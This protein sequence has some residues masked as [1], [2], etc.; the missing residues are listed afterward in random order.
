MKLKMVSAALMVAF[1]TAAGAAHAT[2]KAKDA[3]DPV[4][5]ASK[6][7]K[8]AVESATVGVSNR[9]DAAETARDVTGVDGKAD[10]AK[11][12]RPKKD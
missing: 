7:V 4:C 8:G 6:A 3:V 5:T 10:D 12:K 11:D 9:C 1:V 2:G